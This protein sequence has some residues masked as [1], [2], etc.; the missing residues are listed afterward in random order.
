MKTSRRQNDLLIFQWTLL[1][2]A[3]FLISF[4]GKAEFQKH[5]VYTCVGKFRSDRRRCNQT[6]LIWGGWMCHGQ[7]C[8]LEPNQPNGHTWNFGVPWPYWHR[9]WTAVSNPE[10]SNRR[11]QLHSDTASCDYCEQ[12][13][14][15]YR[16][17][18]NQMVELSDMIIGGQQES[19]MQKKEKE[20]RVSVISL[21]Q[22]TARKKIPATCYSIEG[23]KTTGTNVV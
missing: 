20:S 6:K 23:R 21:P 13:F 5:E 3:S 9:M 16:M 12:N 2:L 11:A 8:L 19:S 17:E 18:G 4:A 15:M 7:L 14:A 10:Y 1:P 22:S